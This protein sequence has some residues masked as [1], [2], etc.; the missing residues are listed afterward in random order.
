VKKRGAPTTLNLA[1]ITLV[2]LFMSALP[3]HAYVGPGAGF[4]IVTSFLVFLNALLA[5]LLSLLIW[6]ISIVRR[7]LRRRGLPLEP[8][9]RR[10][11]VLGL[12]GLSPDIVEKLF[13]EG[14]LPE[15]RKVAETGSFSRLRTTCPGI[16]P[17]AWS[18]FQTG[19][20]PGRHGIFDFLT[21]DRNRYLAVLSSVKT[22]S[23]EKSFGLGPVRIKRKRTFTSLLRMSK[24]FWVLLRKYGI[25]S[26]V[27]R[28]PITYPPE[29]LDGHLLSG[30]C[31]PD[32]RGT[33]GSYTL[34]SCSE[35]NCSPGG[36]WSRLEKTGDGSWQ[37]DISG[38][39]L[40]GNV[41]VTRITLRHTGTKWI[42]G[43]ERRKTILVRGELT[44]WLQLGFRA[45]R[46]RIRGIARFSLTRGG[47]DPMLYVTALH[48]DPSSPAVP[49]SHPVHYSRYLA[50]MYG[51]FATLGLAED[52]WALSNGA[53][54]DRTFL[55]QVWSI[56][57]ER[58]KMFSD[59]LKRTGSGLVVCVFD[60]S[61][62]IQHMFWSEGF[63]KGTTIRNMYGRMD[64]LVGETVRKLGKGDR[65]IIMSDHGFTS[66]H[67][68]VDFNRWLVEQGYLVLEDGV[69]FVDTSFHGVDWSRSRAWS[70][71]LAGMML[72]LSGRESKGIVEPGGEADRL[73]GEIIEKLLLLKTSDG[74]SVIRSV[75]RGDALYNGPYLDRGPD[76]VIGTERGFRAGWGC[77]TGGVGKHVLYPNEKHWNG[78]HC[79]DSE[80]VPGVL[81][82]SWKHSR[83]IPS[84]EDI[85]PTVLT[86]LG[87]KPP[88]YME[89]SDI[90]E[91]G[92]NEPS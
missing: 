50:G 1:A 13:A 6:P 5:S 62:R 90:N 42:L 37:G 12:D 34:L 46:S 26:T 15:M 31:V 73:S 45:G 32:L 60:T 74:T 22:G 4:G 83:M 9:A 59:A 25:R 86:K 66:F 89:G 11:V 88:R 77:V 35:T 39:D 48:V 71:G 54:S 44:S 61:D 51:P 23:L 91:G 41:L 38:P 75:K 27:L 8:A 24:P 14:E 2:L 80:L 81:I 52:T 21:P 67:T 79:H 7:F 57:I 33:Q 55:N 36:V 72:N 3:A 84:I 64:E 16:S 63:D 10:V 56:F 30:M 65:L 78:D 82:T 58:R 87:L 20:N 92:N 28:V 49:V 53:I 85:A 68:C 19:V 69:D 70:M 47:D 17:V 29:S 18:S 40:S 76:L 43:T